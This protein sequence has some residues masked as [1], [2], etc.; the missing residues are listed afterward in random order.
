M[1]LGYN[2]Y[3]DFLEPPR[4]KLGEQYCIQH[5]YISNSGKQSLKGFHDCVIIECQASQ[6]V[7]F[8][9]NTVHTNVMVRNKMF[10]D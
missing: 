5:G 3:Q 10:K 2:G 1:V 7:K 8:T 4:P 6:W 9:K